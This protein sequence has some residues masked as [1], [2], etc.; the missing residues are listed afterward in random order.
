[1]R[2][3]VLRVIYLTKRGG[4]LAI[5]RSLNTTLLG[6]NKLRKSREK[7]N[8]KYEQKKLKKVEHDFVLNVSLSFL[9]S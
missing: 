4:G 1:M 6:R 3:C 8:K 2:T 5:R 9:S 7:R